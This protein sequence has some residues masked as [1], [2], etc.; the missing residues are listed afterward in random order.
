[1]SRTPYL[2]VYAVDPPV[3]RIGTKIAIFASIS[4]DTGT[5]VVEDGIGRITHVVCGPNTNIP[6]IVNAERSN[7]LNVGGVVDGR[8]TT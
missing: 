5:R 1:M 3:Q 2:R 7:V 8:W 4:Q 6:V